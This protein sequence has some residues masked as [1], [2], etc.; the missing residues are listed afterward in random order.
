M[1]VCP[2]QIA[3]DLII[4]FLIFELSEYFLSAIISNAKVNNELPANTADASPNLI[5]V[6][7]F[8]LLIESLS[9]HGKSSWIREYECMHSTAAQIFMSFISF[10]L[11]IFPFKNYSRSYFFPPEIT[12]YFMVL[13]KE[14]FLIF[15]KIY[16]KIIYF[17]CI[18]NNFF[19]IYFYYL[20]FL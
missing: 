4:S 2:E 9:M 15:N 3:K 17:F 7:G 20:K 13:P 11:N 5:C 6:E 14:I 16:Q 12:P 1:P 8:P 10:M 19:I 18:L